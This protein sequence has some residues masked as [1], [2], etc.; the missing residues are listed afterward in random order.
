MTTKFQPTIWLRLRLPAVLLMLVAM[1]LQPTHSTYAQSGTLVYAVTA[2]NRLLQLNSA[3][4]ETIL[5]ARSISGLQSGESI[6]GIDFRPA[7]GQLYALGSSNRVYT[8]QPQTGAASLVAIQ[9]LS[10]TL[11][12][13]AFGVDFNPIPD[14][15]R[16]VSNE[17][18]NLRLHPISGTVAGIDTTLAFTDTD[19]NA[20]ANPQ[21]VGAAY[22]NN[23]SGT[24]TTTL[25]AINANLD[26]L[27]TQGGI[28]GTPSP[29]GGKL[30]TVGSLGVDAGDQVGF[31]ISPA[32]DALAAISAPG[33]SSSALYAIDVSSGSA[34]L[35]GTIGGGEVIVG[36]AMPTVAPAP[37]PQEAIY[38]VTSGNRLIQFNSAV[39][40]TLSA[41]TPITGLQAGETLVGIDFRPAN[42]RLYGVGSSSRIYLIEPATGVASLVGTQPLSPTLAGAAFGMDF[43]PLPDRIRLVSSDEQ[44][45]RLHPISG[46]VAGIDTTLAYTPTDV[47]NGADPR[48]VAA[49]YTNNFSGAT[50]TTLYVIDVD[51]DILATQGGVNG[52]PSP[53]GGALFTVGK[54]G[55]DTSDL[56][57]FDISP[58]GNAF[59]ALTAAGGTASD[60][61]LVN[62]TTGLVT[63]IGAIAGGETVVG[64][65][66]PTLAAPPPPATTLYA[67]TSANRLISFSS[68][69]PGIVLNTQSV[70]GLQSGETLVGIDFRPAD[71]RLYAV[72]N[73]SRIYTIDLASGAATMVGSQVLSPTLT[74]SAFALDFNPVPDR[75]RLVSNEE[76]NLRLHP[77]SGTVAGV[78]GTLAYTLTDINAGVNPA[79]V[80]AA[81]TNN[82]SGAKSTTLYVIDAELDT[83]A[84]QGGANGSPSPN[85]GNLFTVG[86]LGVDGSSL[87][88]FDITPAG[89]AFAALT[90]PGAGSSDLA[91]VNLMTGRV[92]SLGTIGGGETI[93][94]LA[95]PTLNVQPVGTTITIVKNAQPKA[96]TDFQFHGAFG[97][98]LLDDA[99]SD[100]GD[101]AQK[102]ITYNVTPGEYNFSEA[103]Q[104]GW[105]L[106]D[107]SCTG[108]DFTT[109]L[110]G[111]TVTVRPKSGEQI[112]CTFTNQLRGRIS[113]TKYND[114][115]GN[116][117]QESDEPV[118]PNWGIQ[119]YGSQFATPIYNLTNL[120]GTVTYVNLQPNSYK[121]CEVLQ[122]GWSNT[123]PGTID[124]ATNQ[125]CYSLTTT[126][127][128]DVTLFFGNTMS[129]VRTG[130]QNR[131]DIMS[132]ITLSPDAAIP[133]DAIDTSIYEED[134]RNSIYMPLIVR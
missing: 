31:D 26:I 132:T 30:F 2:S 125:P 3:A 126:P 116:G 131:V 14:R 9:P 22:T 21:I 27:V 124:P 39:P 50:S 104:R 12:G 72:G 19:P 120:S 68:A 29:N 48:I 80:A 59:A 46:T 96:N 87:S 113:V 13:T 100:D 111:R 90:S 130:G 101:S 89:A 110:R 33:G 99:A 43:N 18:Q 83:L 8:I 6:L 42:G 128:Q 97:S 54:L 36:L 119:L 64:I 28:N 114:L 103:T 106:S 127:G 44:N 91:V 17:E 15:I 133:A 81:Y 86:K 122:P 52:L 107:I 60:L 73:S 69:N 118:L 53:N 109:N 37:L 56:T 108:G 55:V 35:I 93:V 77:I 94:G 16:V 45:L 65:A 24:P 134:A 11:Q 7:N 121:V 51:L 76:Q 67:L 88:G 71:G 79:I 98:F 82:I 70:S 5:A 117:T 84:L 123:Q 40:G 78:D 4:P 32:G 20:G 105:F 63:R 74:G 129:S 85:T 92:T 75:I 41:S 49:G 115:N 23:V 112:V 38:A 61:A 57:S 25:Y 58:T 10:P 66:V 47:N 34:T 1:L 102:S 95:A 62:L